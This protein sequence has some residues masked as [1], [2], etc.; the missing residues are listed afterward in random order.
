MR[1]LKNLSSQA[2]QEGGN[3]WDFK[4]AENPPEEVRADK[5]ARD[6]WI[7]RP[8]TDWQVY[9]FNEGF[10]E[11]QRISKLRNDGGGNPV[12]SATGIVSDYDFPEKEEVVL[13][14]AKRMTYPP[15][16]V[17]R[18]LSGNWRFVWLLEEKLMFVSYE[19]AVH[20]FTSFLT[21]AFDLARGLAG[22]DAP[23][24]SAPEKLWTNSGDWRQVSTEVIPASVSRGWLVKASESFSF[25]KSDLG[26]LIPLE[27]VKV[28]LTKKFPLFAEWPGEFKDGS[29][30]PTFWVPASTSPKSATVRA[31]GM[32]TFSANAPKAFYS[33]ADLLGAAFIKQYESLAADR[34][35][36]DIHYDGRLY[37]RKSPDG[38]WQDD[39]V[40]E[41]QRVLKVDRGVS[42]RPD[43]GIS[44]IDRSIVYLRNYKRLKAVGPFVYRPA[45]FFIRESVPTL[46]LSTVRVLPPATGQA[47][48]GGGGNFPFLSDCLDAIFCSRDQLPYLLAHQHWFYKGAYHLEPRS[49]HSLF[50]AGPPNAGKSM[51]SRGILGALAGGAWEARGLLTDS[52][53]NNALF[54]KGYWAIDDNEALSDSRMYLK[55]TALVK[56][57][58]ANSSWESH[59]KYKSPTMV[60]WQGRLVVTLNN[61]E[62]SI[63][64]IPDLEQSIL[65]KL[66]LFKTVNGGVL[67]F[68]DRPD[69]EKLIAKELPYF[70]RYILDYEIPAELRE[71]RFGV[72]PYHEPSLVST[73][74]HSSRTAGFNELLDDWTNT[75]F[76]VLSPVAEFW[77]GTAH[78]LHQALV[79]NNAPGTVKVTP[80]GVGRM[81]S[82][83]KNR[84]GSTLKNSTD[85]KL[86]HWTL[87]RSKSSTK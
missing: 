1:Y 15:N 57:I 7:N 84:P 28:E 8:T 47:S 54:N 22:F 87:S 26:P 56:K 27:E 6:L 40:T 34:S 58:A 53:F 21:L 20:F 78:Q 64:L 86:R 55:W 16:W 2:L 50:I 62:V 38:T 11:N 30:G 5:K 44:D 72:K 85:G 74:Q 76:N 75:Y 68:I 4:P 32:Q 39:D 35:T 45:G 79:A 33:W 71:Q 61:D 48:W 23:A 67:K 51:L 41:L 70:A 77:K 49:G 9:T 66:M 43:H 60:D 24:F 12:H 29:H 73:A 25:D 63:Q 31:M 42:G 37:W 65:D 52:I 13:D 46:N 59:E 10:N 36:K 83:M 18:T 17:E 19:H 80:D 82:A 3:P 69:Q 14:R 81:L